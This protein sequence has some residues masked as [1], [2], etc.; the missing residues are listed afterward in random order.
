MRPSLDEI[1]ATLAR[2]LEL[3]A[4]YLCG[5][6]DVQGEPASPDIHV[7]AVVRRGDL[8]DL[9]LVPG[10]SDLT[11]R[12]EVSVI[13]LSGLKA[14][15][16]GGISTWLM[17]YTLDKMRRGRLIMETA[18]FAALRQRAE[19]DLRLRPSFYA[20]A[21]RDLVAALGEAG[22]AGRPAGGRTV[23]AARAVPARPVLARVMAAN[24]AVLIS[25]ALRTMVKLRR[26]FSKHSDLLSEMSS[27]PTEPPLRLDR[28]M[29]GSTSAAS[30]Q[31]LIGAG[32]FIESLF[33]T[34]GIDS[35]RI[36]TPIE[37]RPARGQ[38]S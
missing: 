4:L 26:A 13:P 19:Q 21:L 25:L 31:A 8:K 17:F 37:C 22:P 28:P 38:I 16:E 14:A 12:V 9:H 11:R 23:P 7:L 18:D 29:A 34:L 15:I 6:F 5:P 35:T 20:S 24:A 1:R 2:R 27:A 3:E 30:A 32:R 36:L 33:K 10:V